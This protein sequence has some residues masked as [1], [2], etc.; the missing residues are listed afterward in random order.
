MLA[1]FEPALVTRYGK[2]QIPE[3]PGRGVEINPTW[4]ENADYQ[5]NEV[6]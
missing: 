2:V 6:E 1:L 4:L 3:A 5:A